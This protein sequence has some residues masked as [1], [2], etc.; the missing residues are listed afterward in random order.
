MLG[1]ELSKMLPEL[2]IAKYELKDANEM[3]KA[4][5][6]KELHKAAYW[7][8]QPPTSGKSMRSSDIWHLAEFTP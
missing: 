2:L 4:G 8:A 3:Y 5:R 1:A 7:D 6:G